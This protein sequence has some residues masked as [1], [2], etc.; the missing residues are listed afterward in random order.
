[1]ICLWLIFFV[2]VNRCTNGQSCPIWCISGGLA[3]HINPIY[4]CGSPFSSPTF[5][6]QK[7]WLSNISKP[8]QLTFVFSTQ[9]SLPVHLD[10]SPK[11]EDILMVKHCFFQC[12]LPSS[13]QRFFMKNFTINGQE[14][15][16]L[17]SFL[18]PSGNMASIGSDRCRR[19]HH[20]RK[21]AIWREIYWRCSEDAR[22]TACHI[23][24][25]AGEK[26]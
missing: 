16:I 15:S 22:L 12:I 25:C 24:V 26:W 1:M 8:F 18:L 2:T 13:T 21:S 6:P 23:H 9:P 19:W 11:E 3:S 5:R 4:E 14:A 20:L 10:V 7:L 17:P